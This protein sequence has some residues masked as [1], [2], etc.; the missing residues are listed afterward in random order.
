MLS[1]DQL[2]V[3]CGHCESTFGHLLDVLTELQ[4]RRPLTQARCDAAN[5]DIAQR[6]KLWVCCTCGKIYCGEEEHA[7]TGQHF[8]AES[9]CLFFCLQK[10]RLWCYRCYIYKDTAESQALIRGLIKEAQDAAKKLRTVSSAAT[11]VSG[12]TTVNTPTSKAFKSEP[13]GL[14]LG[15][16]VNLNRQPAL[17]QTIRSR[18]LGVV[19]SSAELPATTTEITILGDEGQRT[20][21]AGRIRQAAFSVIPLVNHANICYMNALLQVLAHLPVF[22]GYFA[23]MYALLVNFDTGCYAFLL[24]TFT[25]IMAALQGNTEYL[26]PLTGPLPSDTPVRLSSEAFTIAFLSQMSGCIVGDQQDAHEMQIGLLNLLGDALRQLRRPRACPNMFSYIA[27]CQTTNRRV[28]YAP[29]GGIGLVTSLEPFI[30]RSN[31]RG[32]ICTSELISMHMQSETRW[33][34]EGSQ[35][36]LAASLSVSTNS[37]R[38]NAVGQSA[39]AEAVVDTLQ[40]TSPHFSDSFEQAIAMAPSIVYQKD[41]NRVANLAELCSQL[42]AHCNI[43][44]GA[45][46]NLVPR[47]FRGTLVHLFVCPECKTTYQ[48]SES[49]FDLPLV[50]QPRTT[51]QAMLQDSFGKDFRQVTCNACHRSV[52]YEVRTYLYH[53]PPILVTLFKRYNRDDVDKDRSGQLSPEG[54]HALDLAPFLMDSSPHTTYESVVEQDVSGDFS[55]VQ[56][57]TKHIV[58]Q[59]VRKLAHELTIMIYTHALPHDIPELVAALEYLQYSLEHYQIAAL[60]PS[61]SQLLHD[62]YLRFSTEPRS[63]VPPLSAL[64]VLSFTIINLSAYMFNALFSTLYLVMTDRQDDL[65]RVLTSHGSSLALPKALDSK[66]DP[67]HTILW[68]LIIDVKTIVPRMFLERVPQNQGFAAAEHAIQQSSS[69]LLAGSLNHEALDNLKHYKLLSN[70]DALQAGPPTYLLSSF[71]VHT[72]GNHYIAYVRGP[73]KKQESATSETDPTS[74]EDIWY[75]L[76]D[77][78]VTTVNNPP[79]QDAYLAYYT[80]LS[81]PVANYLMMFMVAQLNRAARGQRVDPELETKLT[82]FFLIR[83]RMLRLLRGFLRDPLQLE[84]GTIAPRQTWLVPGDFIYFL[85][86]RVWPLSVDPPFGQDR[87]WK[88]MPLQPAQVARA[89]TVPGNFYYCLSAVFGGDLCDFILLEAGTALATRTLLG[90]GVILGLTRANRGIDTREEE[91]SLYADLLG[92][93]GSDDADHVVCTQWLAQWAKYLFENESRPIEFTTR[94]LHAGPEEVLVVIPRPGLKRHVDYELAPAH[95]WARLSALYPMRTACEILY[96]DLPL[97]TEENVAD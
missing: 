1:R 94:G 90:A 64:N 82:S 31:E 59:L 7:H 70:V 48:L 54:F 76:N 19:L 56:F 3:T 97:T 75:C 21:G 87:L 6:R 52:K 83:D 35:T 73:S 18:S 26:A 88:C 24:Q 15:A 65:L 69:Y 27:S 72:N 85:H 51:L 96:R 89:Y 41:R 45:S 13:V 39:I 12:S 23:A 42:R 92:Y 38:G 62:H 55:P 9:H 16:P 50:Y 84:Y 86:A 2:I 95:V 91:R 29:F 57:V 63:P 58:Y 5:C 74:Q 93:T 4:A 37:T 61:S 43:P 8:E 25:A 80:Q 77:D 67:I 44:L 11:S 22:A 60:N 79:V 36:S 28:A 66:T 81:N 34:L 47:L 32:E 40:T 10:H 14:S 68:L 53:C 30:A 17:K 78:K 20:I 71:V 33:F 46:S 49:F